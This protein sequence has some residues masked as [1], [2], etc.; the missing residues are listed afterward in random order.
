MMAEG[1]GLEPSC[2]EAQPPDSSRAPCL[3]VSLPHKW[4][5]GV[6]SNHLIGRASN[7]VTASL[8]AVR[9]YHAKM[10]GVAGFEPALTSF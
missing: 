10:V 1:E 6:E 5:R 4:W 7:W 2:A 8:R 3:S 9:N